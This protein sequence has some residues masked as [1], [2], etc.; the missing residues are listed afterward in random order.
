MTAPCETR[1]S[2][3][4]QLRTATQSEHQA[5]ESALGLGRAD[6]TAATYCRVVLRFYGFYLP[7]E[8]DIRAL[9]GWD[10]YGLDLAA[11]SKTGL[12][13]TDLVALAVEPS[14]VPLCVDR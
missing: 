10:A 8:D 11:R 6:L 4:D 12:L 3:L 7:V 13:K 2:R 14:G 5:I 9:G 1:R